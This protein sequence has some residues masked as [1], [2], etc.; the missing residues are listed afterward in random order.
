MSGDSPDLSRLTVREYT[1]LLGSDA[2][3]PGGGSAAAFAGAFGGSLV[4]MVC[5]INL[6]R[7]KNPEPVKSAENLKKAEPLRRA[8]LDLATKDA[9]SYAKI[10][11]HWKSKSPEL[12][13]ALAEACE[14]PLEIAGRSVDLLKISQTEIR[15]TSPQLTGDL[16][17]AVLLLTA[18]VRSSRLHVEANA[19]AMKDAA[20]AGKS[21][22]RMRALLD[23]AETIAAAFEP[24][25]KGK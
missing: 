21:R 1:D 9:A 23:E 14:V 10:A 20:H 13:K 15:R 25:E 6:K 3:S 19:Q 18:A 5:G 11:E 4:E 2:P 16:I 7:T 22:R 8:L 17:E 24:L 12:E